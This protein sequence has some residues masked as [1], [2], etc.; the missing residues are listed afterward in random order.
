MAQDCKTAAGIAVIWL[1]TS[2]VGPG[3]RASSSAGENGSHPP[4]LQR[5]AAMTNGIH[6]TEY[7]VKLPFL[8]PPAQSISAHTGLAQ[9]SNGDHAMLPCRDSS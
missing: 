8:N 1:T 3:R 9:L 7:P 4:P 6:A 2:I 5:E